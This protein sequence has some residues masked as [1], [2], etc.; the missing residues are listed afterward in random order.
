M[1]HQKSNKIASVKGESNLIR[2]I[3]ASRLPTL[4]SRRNKGKQQGEKHEN[5][6]KRKTNII[7]DAMIGPSR[8]SED[9]RRKRAT[10]N[11]SYE[12]DREVGRREKGEED[13]SAFRE[14]RKI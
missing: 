12:R 14:R 4:T 7:T 13:E 11:Q 2:R 8:S 9:R 6:R 5:A 10:P 3:R 1:I